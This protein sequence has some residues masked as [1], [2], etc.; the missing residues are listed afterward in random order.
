MVSIKRGLDLPISGVPKQ[1]IG[2]SNGQVETVGVVGTNFVEMKPTMYVKVGDEVK[3][4]SKLFEDKKNPGV[5]FTAPASGKILEVNRGHRRAFQSI[6]IAVSGDSHETFSSY[7]SGETDSLNRDGVVSLMLESGMW[8]ALRTRPYSKSPAVDSKPNALFINCTDTN[9]L[10]A[11]PGVILKEYE[12]DFKAGVRVLSK[13][14]EGSTFVCKNKGTNLSLD[15]SVKVE[16]F[17]GV[18]PSGNV[19]THMHFLSPASENKINWHIGYQD[20][21]AVGKLF[22]TGKLWT[23]RVISIGGPLVNNPRLLKTRLGANC[24]DLLKGELG[25]G[26]PRIVSGS[27]LL[28]K[29]CWGP[30]SYLGRFDLQISVLMEGREREFLGWHMPGFNKFSVKRIFASMMTPGKKFDLTSSREGSYRAM[31]PIGMFEKVMPLDILPTQLLRALITKNTDLAQ[32]L[33]CLELDEEDLALCTYVDPGK[34]D[35]GPIL[36]ENL[37]IIEKEG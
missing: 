11:D 24:L 29:K 15:G 3:V 18:H 27:V 20:V 1:E 30:F 9:P 25:I 36:R 28:G 19:G 10:A 2:E 16:D 22:S 14:C 26:E 8:T 23:E 13:L 6:V 5:L 31:V 37:T 32:Q 17:S 21:I 34:V 7:K 4:G 33:G 35:Y 12:E